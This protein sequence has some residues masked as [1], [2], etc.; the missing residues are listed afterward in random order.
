M[1]ASTLRA[2]ASVLVVVDIQPSFLSGIV[3][4]DRVLERSEF[5][6]KVA[7]LLEIPVL[8]TEQYPSRMGGTH[9]RLL[10]LLHAEPPMGKMSFS[11]SG[12]EAFREQI[13]SLNRKQV[14]LVGIETHICVSQTAHDLLR[15]GYEVIIGADAVSARTMDRHKIG[16]KR[17]RDAGAVTAHTESMAYEW[18]QSAEHPRFREVLKIVKE[19][20]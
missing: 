4:S 8:T 12:C 16:L 14:V 11:C 17:I 15:S 10:P 19:Y 13:E 20:A 1:A 18:M 6:L 2:E 7:R 3:E 5:L 9:E